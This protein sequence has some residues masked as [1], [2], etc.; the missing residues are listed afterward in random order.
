MNIAVLMGII[1][2]NVGISIWNC[3]ACGKAWKDVH[4]I[5]SWFDKLLI[6]SGVIQSAIGFSLPLLLGLTWVTTGVMANLKEP[7]LTPAEV[8]QIWEYV[9]SLWYVII[10]LPV[11]G[12]GL[13]ITMYSIAHAMHARDF[14]SMAIAGYNVVATAN[15]VMHAV[16]DIGGAL[17]NVGELFQDALTDSG[18][19]A[20]GKIALIVILLVALSIIGGFSLAFGLVRY[21]ASREESAI[22]E[23]AKQVPSSGQPAHA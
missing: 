10:I 14:A 13:T 9:S 20:K 5:G 2:L 1:L 17:G 21:F 23:Y 4:A 15:N 19:D 12:T 3:H 18:G 7:M 22:E 6:W 16:H 8:T 11:L